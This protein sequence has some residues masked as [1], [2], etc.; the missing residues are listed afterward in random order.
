MNLRT[1]KRV[2]ITD[3]LAE[4]QVISVLSSSFKDKNTSASAHKMQIYSLFCFLSSLN[5]QFILASK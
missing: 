5:Y 4:W 3:T 1:K 2:I